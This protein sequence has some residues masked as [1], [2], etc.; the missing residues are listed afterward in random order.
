MW[1]LVANTSAGSSIPATTTSRS[2]PQASSALATASSNSSSLLSKWLA[3]AAE[4]D[5]C[6]VCDLLMLAEVLCSARSLRP[7]ATNLRRGCALVGGRF[8]CCVG[9]IRWTPVHSRRSSVVSTRWSTTSPPLMLILCSAAECSA[10]LRS[11]RAQNEPS[12]RNA[13]EVQLLRSVV[14]DK[15]PSRLGDAAVGIRCGSSAPSTVMRRR[16]PGRIV[17]LVGQISMLY[18][19]I[20]P[21]F[22][23]QLAAF[24]WN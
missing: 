23:G 9:R 11:S 1:K 21:R 5:P 10:A 8:V 7:A 12:D 2:A 20:A 16:C 15:S 4:P 22:D 13:E 6:R 24:V 19:S 18:V 3:E 17:Q 14:T